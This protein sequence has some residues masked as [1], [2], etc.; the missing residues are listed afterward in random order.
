[1]T[2][3]E[4]NK[5]LAGWRERNREKIRAQHQAWYSAH[6]HEPKLKSEK[7]AF[8]K[9]WEERN[10]DRLREYRRR[11]VLENIEAVR[12]RKKAWYAANPDIVREMRRRELDNPKARIA[13]YMRSRLRSALL[14]KKAMKRG[15]LI[16]LLGMNIPEVMK[17]LEARFTHGMSW[18]NYGEWHVDHIQPISSFDLLTVEGQKAA[19]HYTNLQP[20]WAKDNMKKG[21]KKIG[22]ESR[23]EH[24]NLAP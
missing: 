3:E 16:E 4:R 14:S 5:Y 17:H 9:S 21:K 15:S 8:Y 7:R 12:A 11:Y 19:M 20:L 6:K 24:N 13:L 23:Q 18:D 1:M 22:Y 10:K 2:K